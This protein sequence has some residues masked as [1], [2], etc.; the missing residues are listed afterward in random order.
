MAPIDDVRCTRRPEDDHRV[1]LVPHVL[2]EVLEALLLEVPTCSSPTA[3]W[4]GC[5]FA[6]LHEHIAPFRIDGAHFDDGFDQ[7][8]SKCGRSRAR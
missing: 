3:I 1:P 4:V 6:N 8:D 5:R 2:G 7:L